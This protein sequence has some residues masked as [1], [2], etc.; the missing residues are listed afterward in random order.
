MLRPSRF[1][2]SAPEEVDGWLHR[3]LGHLL[4]GPEFVIDGGA[5]A[6][7]AL[8]EPAEAH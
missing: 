8:V 7:M 5:T 1:R 3:Q 2:V 6:G 4:E